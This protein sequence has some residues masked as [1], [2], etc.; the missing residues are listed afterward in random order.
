MAFLEAGFPESDFERTFLAVLLTSCAVLS[1]PHS[2]SV[3]SFPI[4][5]IELM[6]MLPLEIVVGSNEVSHLK[7]LVQR[8]S[9]SKHS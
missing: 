6:V 1:K 3:V 2:L 5:N 7:Q 4:F 9:H 8:W